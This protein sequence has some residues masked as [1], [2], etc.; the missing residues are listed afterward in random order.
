MPLQWAGTQNN[1]GNAF[2][3][4][5]ERE[6]STVRLGEAV[7]AYQ[8]ALQEWSCHHVPLQWASTQNNLGLALW[9]L[10]EQ[11]GETARMEEAVAAYRAAL[12][13]R[14][15]DRVPLQWAAT[16][17]NLGLALQTLWGTGERDSATGGGPG[18]RGVPNGYRDGLAGRAGAGSAVT[19]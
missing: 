16:R 5:G 10:G 2:R 13:Q 15:R 14:P 18:L 19:S 11:T 1:L 17:N 7:T 3:M 8:A 6:S 9:R 12:E 4:L